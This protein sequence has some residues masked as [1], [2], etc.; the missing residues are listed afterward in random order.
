M[1]FLLNKY[2]VISAIIVMLQIGYCIFLYFKLDYQ[3]SHDTSKGW[4]G[5]GTMIDLWEQIPFLI[6][7]LLFFVLSRLVKNTNKGQIIS[8]LALMIITVLI[9]VCFI[10]KHF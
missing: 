4:G 1:N 5:F 3:I 10:L 9:N 2:K 8:L 6:F 7:Q